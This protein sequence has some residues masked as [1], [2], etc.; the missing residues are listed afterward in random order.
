MWE[1]PRPPALVPSTRRVRVVLGGQ[2]L[3]DTTRSYRVLETS[4]PPTWYLPAADFLPGALRP[5]AGSSFCE[6]KG[7]AA[8]LDLLG[9]G[10]ERPRAAWTYPAPSPAFAALAGHVALYAQAVDACLVD[11]EQV[12]PQ[13]GGFYGGWITSEVVGPFK[14]QPGSSGW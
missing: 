9:G 14:G 8:Y 10:L 5:A 3:V 2:T 13:P 1:Y 12:T 7:Q 6:W 4:H 11:D